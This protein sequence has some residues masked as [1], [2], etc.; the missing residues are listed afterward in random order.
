MDCIHVA[1]Q[2]DRAKLS[3]QSFMKGEAFAMRLRSPEGRALH[4]VRSEYIRGI[5]LKRNLR[6][7]CASHVLFKYDVFF[8]TTTYLLKYFKRFRREPRLLLIIKNDYWKLRRCKLLCASISNIFPLLSN[9][10]NLFRLR[11]QITWNFSSFWPYSSLC[12][13]LFRKTT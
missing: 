10:K 6:H 12:F 3:E 9:V 7:S 4:A 11:P 5:S 1:R 8:S 2:T 13:F